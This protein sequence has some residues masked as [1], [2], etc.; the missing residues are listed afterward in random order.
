MDQMTRREMGFVLLAN[1][2][3]IFF[4][5]DIIV[6]F[7]ILRDYLHGSYRHSNHSEY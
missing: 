4:P 6:I 5:S 2:S 1:P 7:R 3:W